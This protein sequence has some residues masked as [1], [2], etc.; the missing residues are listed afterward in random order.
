MLT[1]N[2]S[3]VFSVITDGDNVTA[4][5]VTKTELVENELQNEIKNALGALLGMEEH[6]G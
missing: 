2:H 5:V 1:S 3:I 6:D 4:V